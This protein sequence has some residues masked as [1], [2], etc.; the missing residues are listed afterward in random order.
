[1]L[2]FDPPWLQQQHDLLHL[3]IYNNEDSEPHEIKIGKYTV[4][5]HVAIN[6]LAAIFICLS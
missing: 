4:F 6:V 5:H 3:R 2:T 1:M